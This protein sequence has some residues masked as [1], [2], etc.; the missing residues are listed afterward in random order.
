VT[1]AFERGDGAV[2]LHVSFA[3]Q[4][5]MDEQAIVSIDIGGPERFC[6]DR[7]EPL[8]VLAGRFRQQLLEPCPEICNAGRGD[9]GNLVSARF[10]E[11]A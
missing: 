11:H 9:D 1:R 3:R 5:H 4:S 8:A 2:L 7:D 6:I 10:S